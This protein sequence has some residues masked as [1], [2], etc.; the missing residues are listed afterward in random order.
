MCGR[1]IVLLPAAIARSTVSHSVC[2]EVVRCLSVPVSSSRNIGT[3]CSSTIIYAI[4]ERLRFT[5]GDKLH[6]FGSCALVRVDIR[7]IYSASC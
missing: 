6:L 4:N 2:G 1:I 3:A 7:H 5:I